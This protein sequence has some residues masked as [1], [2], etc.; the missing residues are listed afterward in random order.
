LAAIRSCST[1]LSYAK[2]GI[3]DAQ[4]PIEGYDELSVE[5]VT[6]RLGA[7]SAEDFREVRDYEERNKNR[8]TILE[9][10]DRRIRSGSS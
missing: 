8:E 5:K 9:Q 3:R 2:E 7:L 10:L 1:S 6:S 4:F